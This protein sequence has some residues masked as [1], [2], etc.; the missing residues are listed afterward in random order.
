MTNLIR[1]STEHT[2]FTTSENTSL[3][4]EERKEEKS[5]KAVVAR[6]CF[7]LSVK[8][9][10]VGDEQLNLDEDRFSAPAADSL[11]NDFDDLPCSNTLQSSSASTQPKPDNKPVKHQH[12][13]GRGDRVV[14]SINPPIFESSARTGLLTR[15]SALSTESVDTLRLN[16][17]LNSALDRYPNRATDAL[18]YFQQAIATREK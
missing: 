15:L 9:E 1:S 14:T 2:A 13:N 17:I 6:S 4:S 18:E 10:L 11:Q 7:S 16:T 12:D 3:Q 5:D 8:D